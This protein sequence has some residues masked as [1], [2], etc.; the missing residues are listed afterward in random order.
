MTLQSLA[1]KT[2][3]PVVA[4]RVQVARLLAAA[5]RNLADA[6]IAS[7]S[8]ENRFDAACK[9]IMQLAMV[10]LNANGWRTC[11][12]VPGRGQAT[13]LQTLASTVGVAPQKV[14]LLDA[15]RKQR[16][17]SDYAGEPVSRRSPRL[18]PH[19]AAARG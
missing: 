6:Q 11:T 19:C 14:R 16:N 17:L 7:V 13:A 10:A 1:G 15:L 12:S 8:A 5:E 9:A 2:L 4:D 3:K 18:P